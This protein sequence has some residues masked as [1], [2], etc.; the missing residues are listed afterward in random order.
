MAMSEA[1]LIQGAFR[2]AA[3]RGA[4]VHFV[5]TTSGGFDVYSVGSSKDVDTA[6]AVTVRGDEY[7]CTCPS[8]LRPACWHRAAVFNHRASRAAFGLPVT[9][10]RVTPAAPRRLPPTEDAAWLDE[11]DAR[12][13]ARRRLAAIETEFA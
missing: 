2:R 13:A 12:D 5:A 11:Q 9:A 6:Y 7:R 8:E 1:Q 4:A 3:G 10:A